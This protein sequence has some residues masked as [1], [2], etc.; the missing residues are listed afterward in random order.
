MAGV[1]TFGVP[2]RRGPFTPADTISV[3]RFGGFIAD[4]EQA[5]VES[6][7]EA[8]DRTAAFR[9]ASGTRLHDE[10]NAFI[11][12]GDLHPETVERFREERNPMLTFDE[13]RTAVADRGLS[14]HLTIPEKGITR[15]AL[16][17]LMLWKDQE[18]DRQARRAEAP[19]DWA[20]IGL[21]VL[22][23]ISASVLDPASLTAAMLPLGG[24]ARLLQAGTRGGRAV[25]GA[26]AGAVAGT[27]EAALFEPI[28]YNSMQLQQ[29][30][31]DLT[32]SALNIAFGGAF[33]G[34]LGGLGGALRRGQQ[35]ER[36]AVPL[37]PPEVQRAVVAQ[38]L[39]SIEEGRP[40]RA[41]EVMA[42]AA[43]NDPRVARAIQEA[44]N[45]AGTAIDTV[46]P[47]RGEAMVADA[48]V[49]RVNF[50]SPDAPDVA[51]LAAEIGRLRKA[52]TAP[53]RRE[54]LNN[55]IADRGGINPDDPLASD[56]RALTGGKKQRP[57]FYSRNGEGV[58]R[59]REAAAE[60]GYFGAG[61]DPQTVSND[62][63]LEAVR[64]ES[65][66]ERVF[67]PERL[68]EFDADAEAM[69]VMDD[70]IGRST[71][72]WDMPDEEIAR[73]LIEADAAA[74]AQLDNAAA[75]RNASDVPEWFDREW[76]EMSRR[77]EEAPD[78]FDD[79]QF[80]RIIDERLEEEQIN[81]NTLLEAGD[82]TDADRVGLEQE[83]EAIERE[84]AGWTNAVKQ[85]ELCLIRSGGL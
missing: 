12:E 39:V 28:I 26:A 21:G 62:E 33:G 72:S 2:V 46:M 13:A 4:F 27:T 41:V 5:L 65:D 10:F 9:E 55:F 44:V 35:P 25:R 66:G 71:A 70:A 81:F 48:D 83:I 6:P 68:A 29:A 20:Q 7:M 14:E 84:F 67:P 22:A 23:G 3:G 53:P 63:F 49:G 60:A 74:Q 34:I 77:A 75:A 11:R 56:L 79:A 64:K 58:D 61:R 36:P 52:P 47:G 45:P 73:T 37:M 82:L 19:D 32:D 17:L 80:D 1:S 59:M 43:E 69:R 38:G 85:T 24:P 16:N 51:T 30:D 40:V 50:N 8:L 42:Q 54:S 15:N 18:L 78:M 76:Q 31:Y 57:G